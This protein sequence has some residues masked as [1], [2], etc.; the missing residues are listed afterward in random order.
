MTTYLLENCTGCKQKKLVTISK[1]PNVITW[2][3]LNCSIGIVH[4]LFRGERVDAIN[5]HWLIHF[6]RLSYVLR[7]RKK[8]FLCTCT[9]SPINRCVVFIERFLQRFCSWR[10]LGVIS[11]SSFFA[12][13][14][15]ACR[16]VKILILRFTQVTCPKRSKH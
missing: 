1:F 6:K 15:S 8:H 9:F 3:G 5:L 16:G 14:I 10:A 7:R 13:I 4:Y 11:M 12:T 2:D